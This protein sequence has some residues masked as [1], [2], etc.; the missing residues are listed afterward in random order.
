MRLVNQSRTLAEVAA[1]LQE[2]EEEDDR[3]TLC[4]VIVEHWRVLRGGGAEEDVVVDE[5]WAGRNVRR[6]LGYYHF[7]N[8]KIRAGLARYNA[9]VANDPKAPKAPCKLGSIP[10]APKTKLGRRHIEINTT[11]LQDLLCHLDG[12][13]KSDKERSWD[14]LLQLEPLPGRDDLRRVKGIK[15]KFRKWAFDWRIMTDGVSMSVEMVEPGKAV[16]AGSKKR[17][18]N[19]SGG[20]MAASKRKK[21]GRKKPPDPQPEPPAAPAPGPAMEIRRTGADPGR[22]SL[23][24]TCPVRMVEEGQPGSE[25]RGRR[26][27]ESGPVQALTKSQYRHESLLKASV[28]HE[29]RR[30]QKNQDLTT[31]LNR[32]DRSGTAAEQLE[33]LRAVSENYAEVKEKLIRPRRSARLA[34]GIYMERPRCIDRFLRSLHSEETVKEDGKLHLALGDAEFASGGRGE[35]SVPTVWLRSRM[36]LHTRGENAWLSIEPVKE[37]M[38]TRGC[39]R[40]RRTAN[41]EVRVAGESYARRGLK[42]CPCCQVVMSRDGNAARTMAILSGLDEA[43]RPAL[44]RRPAPVQPGGPPRVARAR[45]PVAEYGVATMRWSKRLATYRV[46]EVQHGR[47]NG[48]PY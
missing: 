6:T 5:G 36:D 17:K 43:E 41:C 48:P 9:E 25:L 7:L 27:L 32:G 3:E 37:Y 15:G 16:L 11:A 2:V 29:K 21:G 20:A 46:V 40:C 18:Q 42:Y 28:R 38:T 33:Y 39:G 44:F 14:E 22:T 10:L 8:G 35:V 23:L 13:K 4:E 12:T 45:N 34:L 26:V 1:G 31:A 24:T 19:S 30:S 47:V